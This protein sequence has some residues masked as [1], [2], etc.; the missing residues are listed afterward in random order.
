MQINIH[1]RCHFLAIDGI[2]LR[3]PQPVWIARFNKIEI[4]L[5]EDFRH[6]IIVCVPFKHRIGGQIAHSILNICRVNGS[7]NSRHCRLVGFLFGCSSCQT[8]LL[9]LHGHLGTRVTI[10]VTIDGLRVVFGQQVEPFPS[11]IGNENVATQLV[12]RPIDDVGIAVNVVECQHFVGI[13]VEERLHIRLQ[14]FERRGFSEHEY[15]GQLAVVE[16]NQ[17]GH[18]RLLVLLIGCDRLLNEKLSVDTSRLKTHRLIEIEELL[19]RHS[20]QLF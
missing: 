11:G 10:E 16:A 5:L 14:I 18:L 4:D 17:C 7:R 1:H 20:A 13:G 9:I 2:P 8:G 12:S 19:G 6:L 15:H 3:K